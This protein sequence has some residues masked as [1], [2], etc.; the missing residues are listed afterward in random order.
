MSRALCHHQHQHQHR[1]ARA[2][3]RCHRND[4]LRCSLWATTAAEAATATWAAHVA[5]DG[6]VA[7]RVA[8]S[9]AGSGCT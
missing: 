4:R 7:W 9:V 2:T 6:S 5:E 8:G 3:R 1:D